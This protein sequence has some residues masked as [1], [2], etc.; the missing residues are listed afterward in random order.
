MDNSSKGEKITI[1]MSNLIGP[2]GGSV[3]YFNSV[4]A[5]IHK[6]SESDT[7]TAADIISGVRSIIN[8]KLNIANCSC[9]KDATL[10]LDTLLGFDDTTFG[11]FSQEG[12]QKF[13][14][15]FHNLVNLKLN[16]PVHKWQHRVPPTPASL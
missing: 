15:H 6:I 16:K 4:W 3:A 12:R 5:E 9:R 11:R 1:D 14:C 2:A 7:L 13:F 10:I 8:N